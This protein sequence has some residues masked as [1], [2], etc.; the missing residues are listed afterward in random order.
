[1]LKM[2]GSLALRERLAA[3]VMLRLSLAGARTNFRL[4]GT[5]CEKGRHPKETAL[6]TT[7]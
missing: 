1:M 4:I 5:R 3:N 2:C 6:L 7:W